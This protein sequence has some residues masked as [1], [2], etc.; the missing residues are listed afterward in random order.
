MPLNSNEQ[1]AKRYPDTIEVDGNKRTRI[2][3]KD[4]CYV[5]EYGPANVWLYYPIR[6]ADGL[7]CWSR[8]LDAQP[9]PELDP[10]H[11]R[12]RLSNSGQISYLSPH[13][14]VY[15]DESTLAMIQNYQ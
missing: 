13:G 6:A 10:E 14:F 3:V 4:L 5:G 12:C 8:V 7:D 9:W 15:V 1:I 11:W 2:D